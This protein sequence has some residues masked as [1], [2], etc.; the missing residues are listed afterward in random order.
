MKNILQMG[1][2]VVVLLGAGVLLYF[3]FRNMTLETVVPD[4]AP[5]VY[6]N[7]EYGF[8]FALPVEWKGYTIVKDMWRGVAVTGTST[9]SGPKI[10]IRN[11][12]WTAESPH[13]D[14]PILIF[15]TSQWQ[16]YTA[17]D[18]SVSAAPIQADELA[19]NNVYVF[20]LPPRWDFD[21]SLEYKE[22][23]DIV[24]RKPLS[25]FSV[26]VPSAP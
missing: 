24:A 7:A 8:N 21:Y 17:E 13:Q 11:P 3:L 23:Q 9:P 18:F 15:T 14:I 6:V 12:K 1:A 26:K 22:A 2:V 5:L 10:L 19:R 25:A 20:A 4:S 16:A